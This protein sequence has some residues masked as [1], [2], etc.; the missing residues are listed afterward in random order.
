MNNFKSFEELECWK[1]ARNLRLFI[2]NNIITK[3]PSSE[4]FVLIDQ[5]KRSSRSVCNNI[6]EGYGRYHFQ[7][8]IQFCRIARGSLFETLDHAIIALDEGYILEEDLKELR[9]I[10]NKTLLILNGY[11][12]Y[13]MGQK[14]K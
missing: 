12:K 10:H 7:E 5:I 6:S 3:I 9:V 13:L 14:D 2:K 1:E 11:I 8:N 4:K